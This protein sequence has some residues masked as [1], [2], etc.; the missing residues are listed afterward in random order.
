MVA[1]EVKHRCTGRNDRQQDCIVQGLYV[2]VFSSIS[3]LKSLYSKILSCTYWATLFV[4]MNS[5]IWTEE[6]VLKAVGEETKLTVM[7]KTCQLLSQL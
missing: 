2:K 4:C 3:I 1:A 6:Q 5:K 7:S